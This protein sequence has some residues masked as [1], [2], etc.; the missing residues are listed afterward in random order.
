MS[1]EDL[2]EAREELLAQREEAMD[3]ASS[4]LHMLNAAE[5][6]LESAWADYQACIES[7]FDVVREARR[8]LCL[9]EM[10]AYQEALNARDA[11]QEE[12]ESAAAAFEEI[13]RQLIDAD[14]EYCDC[15]RKSK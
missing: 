4:A 15:M 10:E 14:L 1:C 6:H 5:D 9:G 11:A 7:E 12:F 13:E 3:Q 2:R 8:L